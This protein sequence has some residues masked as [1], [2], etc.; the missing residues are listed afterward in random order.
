VR[1]LPD[2][3]AEATWVA[4]QVRRALAAGVPAREIAVLYRYNAQ[5][6]PFEQVLTAAGIPYTVADNERFFD[7]PEIAAALTEMR[8]RLEGSAGRGPGWDDE[9]DFGG[10]AE[11]LTGPQ[12]LRE[13]LTDAGFDRNSP[14]DGAGAARDRWESRSA[15]LEL[16]E[17]LPSAELLGSW[18]LLTEL[19]TRRSE[20][21]TVTADVV[22][23]ATLHQAKGLEWDSVFLPRAVEGSL[24]SMYATTDE[25]IAE[26]RRLFYVGITRAKRILVVTAAQQRERRR[27]RCT[28]SRFLADAGLVD[29]AA[30]AA[31]ARASRA[32]KSGGARGSGV[33]TARCARCTAELP[34][35]AAKLGR[36]AAHLTG[37]EAKLFAQLRTWRAGTA[38]E[39]GIPAYRVLPDAALLALVAE[40]PTD[41]GGLLAVPGI[42]PAKAETYGA[43]LLEQLT[44]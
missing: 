41:T 6:A 7:R 30:V 38:R 14:P 29:R 4:A 10:G 21:H 1:Q 32:G 35:A 8:R 24:P 16:V 11:L 13:V 17:A 9:A 44:A 42:G 40:R 34:A 43:A 18:A 28:P 37:V 23:L 15:L 26:E 12:L 36:C 27:G 39:A 25:Q 20:A 31:P 2:E 33:S 5:S 3:T 22:T 19:E